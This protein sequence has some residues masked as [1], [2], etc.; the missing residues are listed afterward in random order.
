MLNVLSPCPNSPCHPGAGRHSTSSSSCLPPETGPSPCNAKVPHSDH[1]IHSKLLNQKTPR[2]FYKGWSVSKK[3][4]REVTSPQGRRASTFSSLDIKI[5]LSSDGRPRAFCL[6]V[7]QRRG[8]TIPEST[9]KHLKDFKLLQIHS[10]SF[11]MIPNACLW[12]E[13]HLLVLHWV[14]HVLVRSPCGDR[15]V[16]QNSSLKRG[17]S[18]SGPSSWGS[19]CILSSHCHCHF[20]YHYILYYIKLYYIVFCYVMLCYV[21]VLLYYI[22]SYHTIVYYI[23]VYHSIL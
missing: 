12:E 14:A 10:N 13:S 18:A 23:I 9:L 15:W 1:P 16:L 11:Q 7:R 2:R 6:L 20:S 3:D 5:G 19:V 22:I 21:N 17:F 8:W 4:N